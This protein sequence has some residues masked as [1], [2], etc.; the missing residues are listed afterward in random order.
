MVIFWDVAL[1]SLVETDRRFRGAY[2]FQHQDSF[3]LSWKWIYIWA[4]NPGCLQQM[5]IY[6][7]RFYTWILL[8]LLLSKIDTS[9]TRGHNRVGFRSTGHLKTEV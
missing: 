5:I 8:M 6:I 3:S 2:C 1:C 7:N 9:S 4:K